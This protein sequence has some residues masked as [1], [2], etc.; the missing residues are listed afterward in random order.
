MDPSV[1]KQYADKL[2]SLPLWFEVKNVT[3]GP[4][5]SFYLTKPMG[6]KCFNRIVFNGMVIMC[7][8]C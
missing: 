6:D 5:D 3:T 2:D 8:I 1:L 7:L 4:D